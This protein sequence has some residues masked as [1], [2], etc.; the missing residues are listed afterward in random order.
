M[1]ALGCYENRP[2]NQLEPALLPK[3]EVPKPT[4]PVSQGS[5]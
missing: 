5:G 1:L 4:A 3:N 2:D